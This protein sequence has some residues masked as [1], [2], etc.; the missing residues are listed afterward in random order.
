MIVD[1]VHG[2]G[3]FEQ[4]KQKRQRSEEMVMMIEDNFKKIRSS[5][6]VSDEMDSETLNFEK[7]ESIEYYE[8]EPCINFAS[9]TE[10]SLAGLTESSEA[11]TDMMMSPA[12]PKLNGIR[13]EIHFKT[14][15]PA[16]KAGSHSTALKVGGASN[17]RRV[18][19]YFSTPKPPGGSRLDMIDLQNRPVKNMKSLNGICDELFQS[20]HVEPM[21]T[22]D[23]CQ[24]CYRLVCDATISHRCCFC[25]KIGCLTCMKNCEACSEFFCLHCSTSNYSSLYERI[26]CLDCEDR[27]K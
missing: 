23:T 3:Q 1:T 14:P 27:G 26:L 17:Q 2:S 6:K 13:R 5:G 4:C 25:M 15:P 20:E 21:M 18:D 7:F 10:S 9:L 24:C 19:D 16:M 8:K 11:S 22:D 12:F